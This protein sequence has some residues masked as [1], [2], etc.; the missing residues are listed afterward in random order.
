MSRIHEALKKAEQ[1]RAVAQASGTGAAA[2][3]PAATVLLRGN[4]AAAEVAGVDGVGSVV[5]SASN[6]LR[7]D[8]LKLHCAHPQWHL[9]P[10]INVFFDSDTGSAGAEQFR[11]LRSRLYQLRA[12]GTQP[13]RTLL[14]TSAIPAEGKTFVANNL[15]QAI[16]RQADSRALLI[17]ADLR[18]PRL[19]VPLGA[20][21]VPGLSDY[22]RG[23][24]DEM[25]IIQHGQVGNLCFIAGGSEVTDPSEL[26]SNWRL[27]SLLDRVTPV[28][29]WVI[30]DSPPCLPVAD[31][32]ILADLC[33][34]VLMVLQAGSTPS[35]TA[36]RACQEFRERNL[37]GVV[38]NRAQRS[39]QY[40]RESYNYT[41]SRDSVSPH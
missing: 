6:Y 2:L 11:T 40:G 41:Q 4:G 8:E 26:L 5:L 17:D 27:K 35:E 24:T 29:D 31:A 25:A 10:K 37:V 34:G 9:D 22:L 16:V 32:G 7:F 20:P 33:D 15:A 1:E 3:N 12:N 28:F 21:I 38:L 13:L 18:C 36:Q 19:H 39:A 23:E 30:L 14:V